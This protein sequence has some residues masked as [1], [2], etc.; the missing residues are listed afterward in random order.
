M[1]LPEVVL[2]ESS[3]LR[4]WLTH[5]RLGPRLLDEAAAADPSGGTTAFLT[6]P[7]ITLMIGDLPIRRLFGD[8]SQALSRELLHETSRGLS[9]RRGPRW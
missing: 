9:R 1:H 3:T 7:I 2:D 4:D 6:N 8:P 5:D